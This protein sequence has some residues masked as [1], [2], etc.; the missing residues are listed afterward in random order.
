MFVHLLGVASSSACG[1]HTS[2][3][4]LEGKILIPH[5]ISIIV[6]YLVAFY[7]PFLLH[8]SKDRSGGRRGVGLPGSVRSVP[9]DKVKVCLVPTSLAERDLHLESIYRSARDL[10]WKSRKM[11]GWPWHRWCAPIESGVKKGAG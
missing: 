6:A 1:T 5:L 7:V 4:V 3:L 8:S 11:L 9:Q 10:N 2:V